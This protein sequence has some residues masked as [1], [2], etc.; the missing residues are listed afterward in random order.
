VSLAASPAVKTVA[1]PA[2]ARARLESIDLVR[3][4]VMV[5]MVLD[6][7]RDFVHNVAFT[8]DPTDL[9]RTT[10]LLF[11]TRWITHYCAP[12][13]VFLAG[14]AAYLQRARGATTAELSRFLFTR[15]LWL[16]VLEFTAVRIGT[17]FNLDYAFLGVMQVIWAIGVSMV[18]LAGLVH[19]PLAAI[20]TFGVAMIALHN[21][22]D[23]IHVQGWQ[24]PGSPVPGAAARLWMILHQ[25]NEI[26]PLF[27]WPGPVVLLI[28]PLVPWIGV[29]AAGY[30][31]GRVYDL[32]PGRRRR[33]LTMAGAALLMAFIGIRALN[34]Y[35]DPAPWQV[36]PSALFTL[37]SFVNTTKYPPSLLF[38]LMTLGPMMLALAWLEPRRMDNPGARALI[39]FGRVPLFFYL[40]QWPIAHSL[41]IVVSVFAGKD[42]DYYFINPP[43]FFTDVPPNAGF[44]LGTVYACWAV[45]VVILYFL[46]RWYAEVKRRHPRSLLRYL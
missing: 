16:V 18:V 22:L 43:A 38:L 15:G 28:Y 17:W 25:G 24:G 32:D 30:A 29:M 33:V 1:S 9:T 36:Q 20:A 34:I 35:G 10:T 8:F 26:F 13:F 46:C 39:T 12:A 11:L 27:A 7:T 14:V 4:A 45:A 6:H 5:V 44:G 31:F 19:L 21:L 40:L 42:V 23:G 37:L 2:P 41:A 3:G